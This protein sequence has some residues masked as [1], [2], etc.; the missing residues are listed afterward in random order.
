MA[1]TRPSLRALM[2]TLGILRHEPRSLRTHPQL[3]L[4]KFACPAVGEH[5]RGGVVVCAIMPSEGMTP[6]PYTGASRSL[7]WQAVP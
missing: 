4:E 7:Y 3:S 6:A 5:R 2:R 1:P